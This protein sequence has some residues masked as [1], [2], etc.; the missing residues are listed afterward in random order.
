MR[1]SGS[2]QRST[3]SHSVWRLWE[4]FCTTLGVDACLASISGDK[5]PLL[6]LF[7]QPY[8]QGSLQASGRPVRSRTVEDAVRI[9]GQTFARM[10]ARDPRL[11]SFGDVDIR[12]TSLY[13]AWKKDD[14]PPTR[15]KPLPI[16][17]VHGAVH[18]ARTA[19]TPVTLAAAN[20]LTIAFYFLLRPGEYAGT[21]P[22]CGRRP[23]SVPGRPQKNGV[24]GE[25]IGH[26]RSGDPT[27]C[28]VLCLVSHLL[29]LRL[30][31]AAPTTPLNA[32]R[33]SPAAAWQ[34]LQPTAITAFV[35]AAVH[36]S[37]D[38]GI[39][40]SDVSARSTR[41]GGAVALMCAGIDSDRIRLIGR[42][43]SNELYRYLHVQAQPVMNGIA[44]AM[45]RGGNYRLTPGAPPTL[46]A[47]P[48]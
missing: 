28:P 31:G 18:L 3:A 1:T 14:A 23:F 29:Y 4:A 16:S 10:G 13:R 45:F 40:P 9:V 41:A 47:T 19:N 12:L 5:V 38:L 8:K 33:P 27:L 32:T 7:A 43:R 6:Q 36:L 37:P 25:T 22:P 17:L 42:W 26:A 20:C 21:P 39:H 35:R 30:A 15:V 2:A 48:P 34:Y 24:R 44:A 46:P 11:N